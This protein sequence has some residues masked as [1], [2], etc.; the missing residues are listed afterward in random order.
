MELIDL[1]LPSATKWASCN[2]GASQPTDYGNYYSWGG[3]STQLCYSRRASQTYDLGIV[4]LKMGDFVNSNNV[5]SK[6]Y[7]AAFQ[8]LGEDWRI[9]SGEQAQELV[10][11]CNWKWV[12]D[13]NGIKICGKLG[14]SKINGA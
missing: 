10:D 2:L 6:E 3:V 8:M 5:L 9:P 13:Y 4:S 1:G 11:N 14:I 12:E 7:D